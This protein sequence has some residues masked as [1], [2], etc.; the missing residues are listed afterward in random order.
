ML[1]K[2]ECT[3]C[4]CQLLNLNPQYEIEVNSK[5][6]ESS[7]YV[8]SI[9]EYRVITALEYHMREAEIYLKALTAYK[10]RRG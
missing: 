9:Y 3:H 10:E 7:V 2:T 5:T 8:K 6:H 1:H 4:M